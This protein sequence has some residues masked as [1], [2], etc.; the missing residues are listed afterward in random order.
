MFDLITVL[1]RS[2]HLRI[3]CEA[4]SGQPD[5]YEAEE[6]ARTALVEL[7]RGMDMH[8]DPARPARWSDC[9]GLAAKVETAAFALA[10]LREGSFDQAGAVAALSL[11]FGMIAGRMGYDAETIARSG[12]EAARSR[13]EGDQMEAAE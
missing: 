5:N 1:S 3:A 7:A 9:A 13:V 12:D 10:D 6:A 8:L 11:H 4:R 2:R